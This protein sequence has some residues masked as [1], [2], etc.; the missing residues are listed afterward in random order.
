MEQQCLFTLTVCLRD[1]KPLHSLDK[2]SSCAFLGFVDACGIAGLLAQP[3]SLRLAQQR[4]SLR[5]SETYT[6]C[7]SPRTQWWLRFEMTGMPF[8]TPARRKSGVF[9]APGLS[10]LC[11]GLHSCQ[12]LRADRQVVL[13]AVEE[14]RVPN[15]GAG[16]LLKPMLVHVVVHRDFSGNSRHQEWQTTCLMVLFA[17]FYLSG[18]RDQFAGRGP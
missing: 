3:L 5:S 11:R 17:S 8:S 12:D 13:A 14:H 2:G 1:L 4:L 9:T 6:K 7:F 10:L 15:L 18:R 16:G